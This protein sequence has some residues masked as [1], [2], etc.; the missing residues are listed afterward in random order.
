MATKPLLEFQELAFER[1]DI[2][3]F[4]GLSASLCEGELLQISGANGSGKTTLLHILAT[5]RLPSAGCVLWRGE[6][7]GTINSPFR[8]EIA[9]VGHLP[10]VKLYLSA[11][12]N[13]RWYGQ[14]HGVY[15]EDDISAALNSAGLSHCQDQICSTLSSGQLR[16]VA[17]AVLYLRKATLWLLD[18]PLTGLDSGGVR[19]IE[20]LFGSHVN[21]GGIVVFSSHQE[22]AL[23]GVR[24]LRLGNHATG[25]SL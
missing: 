2:P 10:G 23:S 6:D 11:Q 18:E 4:Q 17:L 20:K 14:L 15:V 7:T 8:A 12:E 25:V 3:L 19:T 22:M 21:E 1:N 24:E 9:F 16:R 13:L 5:L